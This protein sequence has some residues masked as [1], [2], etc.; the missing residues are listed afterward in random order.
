M[1]RDLVFWNMRMLE[2]IDA[3]TTPLRDPDHYK[4]E[5]PVADIAEVWRA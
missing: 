5:F 4:Y 1:Q 3:E 2:T